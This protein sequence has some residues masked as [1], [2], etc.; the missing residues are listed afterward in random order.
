MEEVMPKTLL[1]PTDELQIVRALQ[2][3]PGITAAEIA[4]ELGLCPAGVEAY[5]VALDGGKLGIKVQILY[6]F[7]R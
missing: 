2:D 1:T 5:V 4:D 3:A 7:R 6:G